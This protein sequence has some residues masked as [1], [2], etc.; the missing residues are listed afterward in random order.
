MTTQTTKKLLM[1]ALPA[2]LTYVNKWKILDMTGL[3]G[4]IKM[5]TL[6]KQLKQTNT[7]LP[8]TADANHFKT[9]HNDNLHF[10]IHNKRKQDNPV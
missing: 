9:K 8:Q 5:K 1:A 6:L 10:P 7:N 3:R 4:N 2:T